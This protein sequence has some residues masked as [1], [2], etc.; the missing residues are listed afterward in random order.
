[1]GIEGFLVASSVSAIVAQRLVRRTCTH[2]RGPYEPTRDE[3]A[4]LSSV[5]GRPPMTG[6]VRGFGCN[7]CAHTGYLGR[8]GVYE[9]MFVTDAIR[10]LVVDRATHEEMRKVARS[11]GMR[12]LGE[13]AAR[14][15][16]SGLTTLA[17]VIRSIY[18][19]S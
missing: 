3:L 16:E 14:L 17:E 6:F 12:T 5:R 11:E 8:I 2:C 7:F 13:E 1:M 10:E 9:L 19:G 4:F 15:V 18:V